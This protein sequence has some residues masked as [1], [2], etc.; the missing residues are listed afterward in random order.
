M[1]N[2][3][4]EIAVIIAVTF[5][6]VLIMVFSFNIK[7][8]IQGINKKAQNNDESYLDEDKTYNK[9]IEESLV[10]KERNQTSKEDK[11][12]YI[13][14]KENES[15]ISE[16][17]SNSCEYYIDDTARGDLDGD[18][19]IVKDEEEVA[20]NGNSVQSIFKT[21]KDSIINKISG[22]DKLKI[23]KMANSLSVDDYKNLIN[24]VKRSDEVLAAMHIFQL[25][26]NK[27]SD[28]QYKE[29]VTILDPYIDIKMI[30]NKMNEK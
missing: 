23:V 16:N 2:S 21:D 19:S 17:S 13:D 29:L 6:S 1:K 18:I 26:K 28:K 3:R 10:S 5:F 4:K 8:Y 9:S 12:E 20:A 27:L 11:N 24:N 22:S 14:T 30:E 15:S 25:L 7:P